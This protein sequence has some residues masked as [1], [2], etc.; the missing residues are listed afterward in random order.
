LLEHLGREYQN[1]YAAWRGLLQLA[2]HANVGTLEVKGAREAWKGWK[3]VFSSGSYFSRST[4]EGQS[5][6]RLSNSRMVEK[7]RIGNF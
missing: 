4:Y 1:D 7:V 5:S 6:Y 2:N 3:V